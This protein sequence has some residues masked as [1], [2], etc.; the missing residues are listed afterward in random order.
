MFQEA[1]LQRL[2]HHSV[3][4][5]HTEKDLAMDVHGHRPEAFRALLDSR[6]AMTI[7]MRAQVSP[8]IVDTRIVAATQRAAELYGYHDPA[9]LEGQFVS[10]MHHLEDI[11][12]TRLRSTLRALGLIDATEHYEV[13]I[14]QRSGMMRRV[15][16]RVEQRYVGD[17]LV[18]ICHLEPA[19]VRQQFQPPSLP[20]VVPE[21]ALHH[22]FGWACVA[23]VEEMLRQQRLLLTNIHKMSIFRQIK[24]GA[25]ERKTVEPSAM[26]EHTVER[27]LLKAPR[28]YYRCHCLVCDRDW[29]AV[30]KD[31][32]Y[33]EEFSPP[34][35]CNYPDCRADA[36]NDPVAAPG[37][38]RKREQR[39]ARQ[40]N[41]PAN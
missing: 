25:L 14:V 8:S 41:S 19:D 30:G 24:E 6:Q 15:N 33:G 10:L 12:C 39:L 13:R 23:E 36:W 7:A 11:Q 29:I 31:D 4:R 17:T 32:T 3:L 28:P 16:K 1:E 34:K 2:G 27:L 38:R 20:E 26:G 35:R 18:W 21:E 9:E 40:K 37:T 22:F 5:S